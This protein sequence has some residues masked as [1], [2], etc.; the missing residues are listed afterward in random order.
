MYAL[1][2]YQLIPASVSSFTFGSGQWDVTE[3]R[4]RL[5]EDVVQRVLMVIPPNVQFG[6][7]CVGWKWDNNRVFSVRSAYREVMG[8]ATSEDAGRWKMIWRLPVTQ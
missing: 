5:L 1:N 7:D 8:D 4:G 6:V 3:L 2:G